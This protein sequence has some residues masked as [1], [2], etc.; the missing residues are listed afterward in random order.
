MQPLSGAM[1]EWLNS[2]S[3]PR[4][5]T[6]LMIQQQDTQAFMC[7]SHDWQDPHH[8]RGNAGSSLLVTEA[9]AHPDATW[10]DSRA[11]LVIGKQ[12]ATSVTG[13]RR[14]ETLS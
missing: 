14:P 3:A 10:H 2:L 13:A 6:R 1:N 9:S 8:A 5:L 12:Q 7:T 4:S 11:H